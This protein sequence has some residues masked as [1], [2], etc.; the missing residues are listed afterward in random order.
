M[1]T[2]FIHWKFRNALSCIFLFLGAAGVSEAYTRVYIQSDADH[3]YLEQKASDKPESYY[4]FEGIYF[5]GY[6]RDD[7]LKNTAF[8]DIVKGM[9][10]HL[11]RQNF[12]PASS[13]ETCDL[14]LVVSWGTTNPRRFRDVA[15]DIFGDYNDAGY[16]DRVA[17]GDYDETDYS[18]YGKQRNSKLLGFYPY[19]R[20]DRFTG[21]TPQEE[22]EL[23]AAMQTERYFIIVTAF[24]FQ[25]LLNNKTWKRVWST[26]FNMRSPGTN[27]AAAHLA[28][29]KAGAPYY[30]KKME[31]LAHTRADFEPMV[32]EV[33]IG[34][35][36]VLETIDAPKGPGMLN[37][38]RVNEEKH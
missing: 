24:D 25:K 29:S 10:P 23:R 13:K 37:A 8:I 14:L 30:G 19:I 12:W 16:Y 3:Q 31:D 18:W 11:A 6:T 27:F 36:E 5:G 17:K 9:A 32:A 35:I 28:L 15:N 20:R 22:Y 34:D 2:R 7:S 38:L 21:I 1:Q 33:E 26:R 4:F